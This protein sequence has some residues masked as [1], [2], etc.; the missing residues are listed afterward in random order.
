VPADELAEARTVLDDFLAT[1]EQGA[2]AEGEE[3]DGGAAPS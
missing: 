2:P 3:V 1:A